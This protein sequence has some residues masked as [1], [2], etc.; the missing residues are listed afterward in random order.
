[1]YT[2]IWEIE[3]LSIRI[4]KIMV[5]YFILN[6]FMC[7]GCIDMKFVLYLIFVGRARVIFVS[8]ESCHNKLCTTKDHTIQ[9][10]HN[11]HHVVHLQT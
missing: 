7:F 2:N 5:Y 10:I 4:L 9:I 3:L 8:S 6:E 1:M 11:D